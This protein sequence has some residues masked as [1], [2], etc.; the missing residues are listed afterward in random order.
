MIEL[1]EFEKRSEE[2]FITLEFKKVKVTIEGE[3][4]IDKDSTEIVVTDPC[5]DDEIKL[6]YTTRHHSSRKRDDNVLAKV[7]EMLHDG[8]T[9]K[10]ISEAM[11]LSM[12]YVNGVR[13]CVSPRYACLK[14]VVDGWSSVK[15]L[16]KM[17]MESKNG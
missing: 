3:L 7:G 5:V 16:K 4:Y 13:K 11:K 15:E 14:F 6:S 17:R 2:V 10:E 9:N 1:F 12:Q 8:Y